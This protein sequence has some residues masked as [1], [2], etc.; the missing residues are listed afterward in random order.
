[1]AVIA[2]SMQHKIST[3]TA[4]VC[5]IRHRSRLYR[6][7]KISRTEKHAAMQMHSDLINED[8]FSVTMGNVYVVSSVASCGQEAE[9]CFWSVNAA[10]SSD[11]DVFG[12]RLMRPSTKPQMPAP[13]A[14]CTQN[15]RDSTSPEGGSQKDS[16][17]GV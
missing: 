10:S 13:I 14:D 9:V 7:T 4:H 2:V 8:S 11:A 16:N 6:D 12:F 5:E 15:S 17:H 1:M 3:L